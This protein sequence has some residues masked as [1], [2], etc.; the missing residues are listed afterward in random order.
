MELSTSLLSILLIVGL[1]GGVGVAASV[2]GVLAVRRSSD[3][4]V[5]ALGALSGSYW[6]SCL[7][8]M[9]SLYCSWFKNNTWYGGY[10]W[11]G[12]HTL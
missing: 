3:T 2:G 10:V 7:P 5:R 9:P 11:S 4:V 12:T 8:Y 1:M 6:E